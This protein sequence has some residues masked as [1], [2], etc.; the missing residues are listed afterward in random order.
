MVGIASHVLH[1]RF[2]DAQKNISF[3]AGYGAT[4]GADYSGGRALFSVAGMSKLNDRFSLVFDSSL[5]QEPV[6]MTVE[7]Y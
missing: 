1:L 4:W 6:M 5:F 2:G 3:L 7:L